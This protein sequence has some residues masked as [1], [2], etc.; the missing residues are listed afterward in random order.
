M[1]M[2]FGFYVGAHSRTYSAQLQ[3]QS[4]ARCDQPGTIVEAAANNSMGFRMS[5][6]DANDLAKDVVA[7]TRRSRKLPFFAGPSTGKSRSGRTTTIIMMIAMALATVVAGD[8][9]G[10]ERW[11][12]RNFGRRRGVKRAMRAEYVGREGSGNC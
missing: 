7:V 4:V 9:A 3:F 8:D 2:A 11:G 10:G 12:G 1:L 6:A 5:K